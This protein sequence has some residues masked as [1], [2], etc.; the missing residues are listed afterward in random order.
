MAGKNGTAPAAPKV[1]SVKGDALETIKGLSRGDVAFEATTKLQELAKA[2]RETGK[3]G[4]MAIVLKMVPKED[5]G[6]GAML[7]EAEI[8]AK[9]PKPDKKS[10]VRFVT[11]DGMLVKDDPAQMKFNFATQD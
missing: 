4:S 3:G 8:T 10:D 2:V 1:D 5:L 6:A 9:M 11:E 7:I